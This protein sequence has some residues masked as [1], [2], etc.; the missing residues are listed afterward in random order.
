M[1]V[2]LALVLHR[3]LRDGHGVVYEKIVE[4]MY[5]VVLLYDIVE[6]ELYELDWDTMAQNNVMMVIPIILMLVVILVQ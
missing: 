4:P 5:L 2:V 6:M 3:H 1:L